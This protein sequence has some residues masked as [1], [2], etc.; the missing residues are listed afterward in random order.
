M[1]LAI[2]GDA[3][4]S[5]SGL[6]MTRAF[7]SLIHAIGRLRHRLESSTMRFP[8]NPRLFQVVN[9]IPG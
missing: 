7:L 2:D 6:G 9:A 1:K 4:Y 8:A 3:S 5:Q